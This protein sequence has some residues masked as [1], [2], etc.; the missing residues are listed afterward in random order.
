MVTGETKYAPVADE[1]IP[2]ALFV[3]LLKELGLIVPFCKSK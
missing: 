1:A 2:N 3:A